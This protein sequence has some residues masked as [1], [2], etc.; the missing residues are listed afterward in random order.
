MDTT[1]ITTN[2]DEIRS[3]AERRGG[4]PQII[5]LDD[6][7]KSVVGVRI[8]FPGKLDESYA[9]E[10]IEQDA[11]WQRFFTV[12]DGQSLAFEYSDSEPP[13]DELTKLPDF[14]SMYRFIKRNLA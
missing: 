5:E 12:F 3:W 2:H 7:Q 11:S 6:Q 9:I 1:K 4:K 13:R 14:S 10:S 8:D